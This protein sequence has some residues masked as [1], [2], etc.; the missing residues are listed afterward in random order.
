MAPVEYRKQV[1]LLEAIA[2]EEGWLILTSRA[3][4]NHNPGNINWG[5][6]AMMH[7]ATRIESDPGYHDETKFTPR[8]AYF[9]SDKVGFEA[10]SSLLEAAY[11]GKTLYQAIYK[12][13]PPIENNTQQYVN[14]VCKW[15]GL[16]PDTV[17]ESV[18]FQPPI[19]FNSQGNQL[20]IA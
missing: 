18:H 6:F 3:R 19:N 16:S 12:W 10:M 4:R 15:T 14:N 1:T 2:R 11:I 5:K 9:P 13:A 20:E 8:F 17:L 7:G